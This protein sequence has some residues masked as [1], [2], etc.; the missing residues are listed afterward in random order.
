MLEKFEKI[1]EHFAEVEARLSDPAVVADV[2]KFT[3]LAN[4]PHF[5]PL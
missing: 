4:T 1:A 5:C 2:E 3:K